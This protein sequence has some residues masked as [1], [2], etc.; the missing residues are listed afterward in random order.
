[1]VKIKGICWNCGQDAYV[2]EDFICGRCQPYADIDMRMGGSV[3]INLGEYYHS[4]P[5]G[6][7]FEIFEEG[8]FIK[9]G[10]KWNIAEDDFEDCDLEMLFG[11]DKFE[12][13]TNA[14]TNKRN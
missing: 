7:K 14:T 8:E 11:C 5:I 2:D 3:K 12:E 10:L 1:M 4:K 6:C 9:C 13:G